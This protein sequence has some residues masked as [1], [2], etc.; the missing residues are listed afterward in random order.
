MKSIQDWYKEQVLWEDIEDKI[1]KM[2]KKLTIV[3]TACPQQYHVDAAK[4]SYC[5]A[6]LTLYDIN[7]YSKYQI[8]IPKKV[9]ADYPI[10]LALKDHDH[11]VIVHPFGTDAKSNYAL[12]MYQPTNRPFIRFHAADNKLTVDDV[13]IQ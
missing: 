6:V 10:W 4:F 12:I 7:A 1:S 9:I 13:V 11:K 8:K 5:Q 3:K 2:D